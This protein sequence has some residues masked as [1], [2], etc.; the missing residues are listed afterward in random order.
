MLLTLFSEAY[1]LVKG[2]V[3]SCNIIVKEYV[4]L[5]VGFSCIANNLPICPTSE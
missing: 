3:V 2:A 5:S 4:A 1:V